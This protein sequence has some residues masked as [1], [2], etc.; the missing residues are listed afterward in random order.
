MAERANLRVATLTS[1][2][3]TRSLLNGRH[4]KDAVPH[5]L[6]LD[7]LAPGQAKKVKGTIR[8]IAEAL[9]T[10]TEVFDPSDGAARPGSRIWDIFP[11]RIVFDEV[12]SEKGVDSSLALLNRI[13]DLNECYKTCSEDPLSVAVATD[14]SVPDTSRHQ[15]VAGMVV[16]E[17]GR[18]SFRARQASG[19]VL[20]PCAELHAICMAVSYLTTSRR[21]RKRFYIFTD[22]I[23]ASKRSVD[24][25]VH[26]GQGHSLAV[27]KVLH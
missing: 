16:Y 21:D 14:A 15:A 24:L 23:T 18:C 1:T 4:V 22:N 25:S 13:L 6:S 19:S 2:H 9:P 12:V 5:Y 27:C 17:S 20:A 7:S 26:S 10:L 8:E 3:P 11:E